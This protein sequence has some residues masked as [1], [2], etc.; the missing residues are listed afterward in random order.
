M[1][2]VS[3]PSTTEIMDVLVLAGC[4]VDE[5]QTAS[6]AEALTGSMEWLAGVLYPL[7]VRAARNPGQV[8]RPA[9]RAMGRCSTPQPETG[10]SRRVIGGGIIPVMIRLPL[11]RSTLPLLTVVL[12]GC[13]RASEP[14][15]PPEE[16]LLI[17]DSTT[18]ALSVRSING[19]ASAVTI[20]LVGAPATVTEVTARDGWA[21][22]PLGPAD[23]VVVVDLRGDSVSRV[24]VLAT[25][26]G[27]TGAAIVDDSLAYVG[28]PGLNTVT[29]INYLTGDTASVAVGRTPQGLAATRGKVFVLNGNLGGVPGAP[30]WISVVDPVTNRL[31]TGIDSILL[32]GPGNAAYSTLTPDGALYVLNR[33]PV[34]TTTAARLSQVDPVNRQELGSFG[35]FGIAPGP[36]ANNGRDRLY[37][38]SPTE[39]LMVFDLFSRQV[40]R[41]AGNG[42]PITGNSSVAVDSR[43]RIYALE[44]GPC[45]A[46]AS[47]TL[48]VLRSDLSESRALPLTGCPIGAA[49]V[50]IQPEP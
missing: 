16:I 14:L 17:V 44:P 15:P 25:G 42:V 11:R 49:V 18:R 35:G 20:P 39:G 27:A 34:G 31:A 29:R 28:N 50:Q 41:G 22:V 33:G 2:I 23:A 43:G 6:E 9:R 4:G 38:S 13:A 10:G 47:G 30:S 12:F 46:G 48:H 26:S 1:R 36:I 45:T 19:L 40:L 21:I 32:P 37:L 5:A 7:R 24:V 8:A 3:P